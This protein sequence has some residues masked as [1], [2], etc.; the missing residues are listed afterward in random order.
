MRTTIP[1]QT[2]FLRNRLLAQLSV[3]MRSWVRR[4]AD[5]IVRARPFG[6]LEETLLNAAIRQRLPQNS[7]P[8]GREVEAARSILQFLALTDALEQSLDAAG[9]DAQLA[10]VNL[11][12]MMQRQ[13]QSLQEISNISKDLYDTAMAVIR[14]IGE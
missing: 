11:Q 1:V 5:Q 10:N 14:H 6:L 3:S 12:N 7:L 2:A 9:D 4:Q 13:Q 8:G